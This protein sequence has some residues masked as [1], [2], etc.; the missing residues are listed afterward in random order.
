[1]NVCRHRGAEVVSGDGPL[2]D[3]AVPLPRWTYDLDGALRA[4]PRSGVGPGFDRDGARPAAGAG[5]H[6]GPVH[7]RQRRRGRRRRSPTRSASC[8]SSSRGAGLDVDALS[9]HSRVPFS[10]DANWK[11][12]VENYLECYHCAG[13]APELQRRDRRA[14]GRLP[15]RDPPDLRQPLRAP[16][17]RRATGTT[18]RRRGRGPVPPDLAEHQGQRDA[19]GG[20]NMSI[21]PLVPIGA[22]QHRRLPRLLLRGPTATRT[23]SPT[24][25]SW[26]TR[27]APRTASLVGVGPARDALGRVRGGPPDAA[28]ARS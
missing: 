19:A 25:W 16:A 9:F 22:E 4:A 28:R 8:R 21:G 3:A 1:M 5:R 27:S 11:I 6:L 15:A 14:P 23:G 20:P 2:H 18:T 12:A 13:R 17:R 26:T 24:T 7:L 10:L